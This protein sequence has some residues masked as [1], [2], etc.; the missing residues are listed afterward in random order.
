MLAALKRTAST[1]VSTFWNRQRIALVAFAIALLAGLLYL[2]SLRNEFVWDD[3]I[4]VGNPD[5]RTLDAAAVKRVFTTN[6]WDVSDAT[7]GMYRPLTTLSFYTDYHL[8]GNHPAGFHLTNILLNATVCALVFLVLLEMFSQPGMALIAAL[9]FAA[10]PMHVQSVA[11]ISGRTDMVATLFALVSL[12]CYAGWR[13]T[14]GAGAAVGSLLGYALALL[15]KEV[16]VVLPGV[17]VVYEMLTRAGDDG[18]RRGL[19]HWRLLLGMCVLL[20]VY[21]VVR[22]QLLGASVNALPRVTHGFSQALALT[23]SIV[24]HYAYK[25]VFPFRLEPTADFQPPA[26]FFNPYTLGGIV[27]VAIVVWSLIRWRHHHAFVFGVAVI[28]CGLA[29]VVHIVPA[30]VTLAEHFLYFP[31]FGFA[32]LVALA[33]TY[34]LARQRTVAI[35]AFA[36]LLVAFGAATVMGT[37]AW[38]DDLT[39]FEKAVTMSPDNPTAHF[40]YGVSLAQRARYEEALVEFQRATDLN[41]VYPDAWSAMGLAEDQLGSTAEG[42]KHVERA[43]ALDPGDARFMNDLGTMQFKTRQ[44]ADAAQ[45]FRRVLELRP[46][47]DHARFNLGLALYQQSDFAGAIHAFDEIA[48]KDADFP[49][50][51]FFLA[52]CHRRTGN[53]AEAARAARHFLS[54]HTQNDGLAADARKIAAGEE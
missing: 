16:A 14:G 10:F 51:W 53:H 22:R 4:L 29:P 37:S 54:V 19:T 43:V 24:G 30:N 52:Q 25:L 5:I 36:V 8:Y 18:S 35:A 47:H 27:V 1:T 7:S 11:W 3:I 48:N 39:L 34:L 49:N 9:W 42:L 15:G 13:R 44:Y 23:F 38:K 2:P 41:P 28:A 20:V 31:S 33:V 26:S 17:I 6:F 46:R 32:V 12:W 40:D 45:T 50:A 21:F